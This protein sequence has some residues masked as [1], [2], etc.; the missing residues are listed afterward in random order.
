MNIFTTE[1]QSP[2]SLS[3]LRASAVKIW[4]KVE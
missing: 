4:E 2:Q 1:T 3:A